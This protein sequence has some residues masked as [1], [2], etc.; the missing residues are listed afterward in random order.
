MGTNSW[1]DISSGTMVR[2]LSVLSAILGWTSTLAWSV[3]FYPQAILNYRRRSTKG[4]SYDFVYLNAQGF[5]AYSIYNVA[6]F[7]SSGVR[8]EYRRRNGGHDPSVRGNDVAFAVHAFVLSTVT[9]LQTF[10]YRQKS[11][12]QR[13]SSLTSV[14]ISMTTIL[15]L[16]AAVASAVGACAWLDFLYYLSYLKLV[17]SFYKFVPQAWMNFKRKST[18]G[19]SIHNI[20]LDLTGGGCSLAQMLIDAARSDDWGSLR[21]NPAKLI[22]SILA[23]SFD[24]LFITQHYI[25]Y[26]H[27][28]NVKQQQQDQDGDE[29]EAEA[30]AEA[31]ERTSLL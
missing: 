25:L 27:S 11:G 22:L 17:I 26:R 5:L 8:D 28:N 20:L 21:G 15:V 7:A 23:M 24:L 12:S 18:V 29:V 10:V 16:T 30:E 2:A 31:D 14:F 19:W 9:L 3:S 4:L 1:Q 13:V 6:L